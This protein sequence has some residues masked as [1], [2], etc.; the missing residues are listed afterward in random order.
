MPVTAVISPAVSM[1][2]GDMVTC[3]YILD[4]GEDSGRARS[5]LFHSLGVWRAEETTKAGFA[6]FSAEHEAGRTIDPQALKEEN[7]VLGSAQKHMLACSQQTMDFLN[8]FYLFPRRQSHCVM[9][10]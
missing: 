1:S 4:G 9:L 10:I 6:F 2:C 8:L 7:G 3:N 5:P